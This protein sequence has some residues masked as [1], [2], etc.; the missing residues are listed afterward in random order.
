MTDSRI[1]KFPPSE[2]EP[3]PE[4][5][6]A[7]SGPQLDDLSDTELVVL[8]KSCDETTHSEIV[9]VLLT[10]HDAKIRAL[11]YH[12]ARDA[13]PIS[14]EEFA[15]EVVFRFKVELLEGLLRKRRESNET[16]GTAYLMTVVRTTAI[17]L[18]RKVEGRKK[19]KRKRWIAVPIEDLGE[20]KTESDSDANPFA[21][22]EL[23]AQGQMINGLLKEVHAELGGNHAD[24]VKRRAFD[25]LTFPEIA[26]Y[27]DENR[28]DG[29]PHSA[30]TVRKQYDRAC[31]AVERLLESR[32]YRRRQ[33]KDTDER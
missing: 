31:E 27:L 15:E 17:N 13:G 8:G 19:D 26:E 23:K 21:M 11:S 22:F 24:I 3:T 9:R 2:S 20:P 28:P 5:P 18:Y 33:L 1:I 12:L 29:R 4:A 14:R 32:G 7:L 10:R 25:R 16:N 6:R 30:V